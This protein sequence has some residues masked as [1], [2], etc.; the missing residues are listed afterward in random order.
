MRTHPN[1]VGLSHVRGVLMRIAQALHTYVHDLEA[2]PDGLPEWLGDIV[3]LGGDVTAE[4]VL[5]GYAQ[6]I[7]PMDVGLAG[8]ADDDD[9]CPCDECVRDAIPTQIKATSADTAPP[10][11][12][13]NQSPTAGAGDD[14]VG[15]SGHSVLAWWSPLKRG[16]LPLGSLRVTTSLAKSCRRY[17]VTVNQNFEEVLRAC[18][19]PRDNAVWIFDD[20][21]DAYLELHQQGYAHSVETRDLSGRLVGGL[22][23]VE[24][25]GLVNGDSM[26]HVERDASKVALVALIRLLRAAEPAAGLPAWVGGRLLD[27]QWLTPHLQSLGAVEISRRDYVRLLPN[28]LSAQP[29]LGSLRH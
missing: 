17:R 1:R 28:A 24:Q 25:G 18:A 11:D 6:G 12:N 15:P 7:F 21:I 26:F 3:A 16:L 14:V 27:V 13:D 9:E 5:R 8:P 29:A 10:S 22:V 20:F 19:D 23:C 4:S 2:D